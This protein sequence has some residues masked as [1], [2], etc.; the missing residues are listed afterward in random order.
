MFSKLWDEL[1]IVISDISHLKI[2]FSI[3]F[4]FFHFCINNFPW[5]FFPKSLICY[6]PSFC[7][8]SVSFFSVSTNVIS[9]WNEEEKKKLLSSSLD[10]WEDEALW[11]CDLLMGLQLKV[12]EPGIES[13]S[14]GSWSCSKHYAA[15]PWT[16]FILLL[17]SDT[18]TTSPCIDFR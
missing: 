17:C 9:Q 5:C 3:G 7:F 12:V 8:L 2:T 10:G 4:Y 16:V 18:N 1:D 11:V 13:K 14:S 15:L 6:F